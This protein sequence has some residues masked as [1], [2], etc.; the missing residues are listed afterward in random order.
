MLRIIS[1]AA[2][3]AGLFAAAGLLAGP[4]AHASNWATYEVTI[5]NISPGQTFTPQLVVT[6]APSVRLFTLGAPAGD[7]LEML[8]EGGDTGPLTEILSSYG[9]RVGDIQTIDGL[10]GP[11]ESKTA[12]VQARGRQTTLSVA[13]MLIPTN[14]TFVAVDAVPLP[15][16]GEKR[17]LALA[18]D[19]GTEANDQN[20]ANIPGPRC[21]GDGYSPGPN[22]GD[23]GFV[24]VGNGFHELGA[25]DAEGNE[26]LRPAGYDWR[27]PVALVTVRRLYR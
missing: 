16:W 2:A 18:Y 24:H 17:R 10:L 20:C 26:I 19:A 1:I 4:A 12:R 3:A 8:A 13:A 27:N 9:H 14:D 5:T 7:A 25:E 11:G 15:G 23:E 6:H 22:Q 21:G